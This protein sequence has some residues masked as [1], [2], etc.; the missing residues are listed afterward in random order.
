VLK[1]SSLIC[2]NFVFA[3]VILR[4][5]SCDQVM[6]RILMLAITETRTVCNCFCLAVALAVNLNLSPTLF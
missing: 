2:S 5:V 3:E 1:A 6:Q 4:F